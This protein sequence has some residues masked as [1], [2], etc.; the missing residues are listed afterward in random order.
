ME[1]PNTQA[2]MA[3]Q[4]VAQQTMVLPVA[5]VLAGMLVMAGLVGTQVLQAVLEVVVLVA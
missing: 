4:M 5:A 1:P 2:V 3:E